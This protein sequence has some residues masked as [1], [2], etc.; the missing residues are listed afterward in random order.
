MYVAAA[1]DAAMNKNHLDGPHGISQ[2]I[3][4][5]PT[6]PTTLRHKHR[7]PGG[8]R[9]GGVEPTDEKGTPQKNE[10]CCNLVEDALVVAVE[11]RAQL[12]PRHHARRPDETTQNPSRY[13][14]PFAGGEGAADSGRGGRLAVFPAEHGREV[15]LRAQRANLIWIVWA[16]SEIEKHMFTKWPNYCVYEVYNM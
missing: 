14:V 15:R 5:H 8:G 11:I 3:L 10:S 7:T 2:P 1:V 4:C 9:G 12:E 6:R 16:G 13:G